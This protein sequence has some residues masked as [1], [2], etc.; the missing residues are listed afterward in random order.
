MLQGRTSG[1]RPEARWE[2]RSPLQLLFPRGTAG[3]C[4]V[5][6]GR[7]NPSQFSCGISTVS[8]HFD[9]SVIL[10]MTTW[11]RWQQVCNCSSDGGGTGPAEGPRGKLIECLRY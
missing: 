8:D 9:R 10:N 1:P 2:G 7:G 3:S 5:E 6:C 4:T 11:G